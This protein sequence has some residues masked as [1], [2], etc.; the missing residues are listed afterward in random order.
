MTSTATDLDRR[1]GI[2]GVARVTEGHGGL[3][4][5]RVTTPDATGE[6][7]LHGAQV[8]SWAPAGQSEVLFV[9][10]ASRWEAGRA[11][12]GGIPICFPWF[13]NKAGDPQAPAHGFARTS[14]WTLESIA[15]T[16]AGVSVTMATESDDL[17]RARWPFDVR[18]TLRATLGASLQLELLATNTGTNALRFEE[19]LHSY[20]AIGNVETVRVSGLDGVHYLDKVDGGGERLQDGDIAIVAETDRVYVHTVAA[21]DIVDPSL[22]RRIRVDKANSRATVVWNPWIEKSRA[23]ADLKDDD[24]RRMVCV[25]TCNVQ[26][27]A[28]ELRPAEQ[29]VMS[30][31]VTVEA[32]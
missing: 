25:E 27:A 18:L 11:V 21:I 22:G 32:L 29:H 31:A 19:A 13:G 3:T 7:Y 14:V 6:I 15:Q 26:A 1:H 12:R 17:T 16:A 2:A 9:S 5:V 28:I 30:M 23:L 4:K 8:T 24:W 20:Y 10:A